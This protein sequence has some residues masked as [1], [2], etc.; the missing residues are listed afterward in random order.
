MI[1]FTEAEFLQSGGRCGLIGEDDKV[2]VIG[3]SVVNS[4]NG[5]DI[6]LADVESVRASIA[7]VAG[8]E[9]IGSGTSNNENYYA[10]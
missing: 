5:V 1:I 8:V 3:F 7:V 6:G 4:V 10:L 9:S 2:G